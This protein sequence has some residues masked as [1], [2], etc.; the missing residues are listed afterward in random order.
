ML[1]SRK[2]C[3]GLKDALKAHLCG[4]WQDSLVPLH[5]SISNELFT[6]WFPQSKGSKRMKNSNPEGSHKVSCNLISTVTYHQFCHLLLVIQTNLCTIGE[7][8]TQARTT[9]S[10]LV[11]RFH[12]LLTHS[13][14]RTS[15]YVLHIPSS[16]SP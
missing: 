9:K 15:F 14:Q 10:T 8:M 7:R 13:S 16:F 12:T 5:M 3:L 11:A 1:Q 4:C 6:T 2:T